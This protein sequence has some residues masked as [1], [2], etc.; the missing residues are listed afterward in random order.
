[1]VKEFAM[2]SEVKIEET[3]NL[4]DLFKTEEEYNAA[5]VELEKEVDA[6]AEKFNG[7]ITDAESVI[8]ALEGYAAIYEKMVPVGTYTSL[9][10][11]TDQ[12]NDEAQM[13][14]SKFGSIAA[15]INSKLSFVNSELSEL[16][17][18]ILEEAMKQSGEFQKLLR[19]I[20]SQ[21]RVPIAP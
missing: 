7:N 1:M 9:S 15:K 19:E 10:S 17:V 8:E 18:E 6:F 21:K 2:R 14:S 12:T 11:S 20:D 13:R 4:Q 16:P 5:V 3:W